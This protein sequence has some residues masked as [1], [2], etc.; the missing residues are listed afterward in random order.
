VREN[1]NPQKTKNTTSK[2]NSTNADKAECVRSN[3]IQKLQTKNKKTRP[4]LEKN[5]YKLNQNNKPTKITQNTTCVRKIFQTQNLFIEKNKTKVVAK[6]GPTH[7]SK[8]KKKK[9]W[10][11]FFPSTGG[12]FN[13]LRGGG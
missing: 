3:I 10:L 11:I 5:I 1:R 6:A 8:L 4:R 2:Q 13:H 12:Q 9:P 7:G